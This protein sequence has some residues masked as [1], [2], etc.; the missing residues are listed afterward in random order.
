MKRKKT[1]KRKMDKVFLK[2]NFKLEKKQ[3]ISVNTYVGY[4]K[5]VFFRLKVGSRISKSYVC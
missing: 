3:N 5:F 4:A 2:I 1:R